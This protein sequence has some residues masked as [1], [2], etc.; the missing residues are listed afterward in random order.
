MHLVEAA[1]NPKSEILGFAQSAFFSVPKLPQE[2][3]WLHTSMLT[4]LT[5]YLSLSPCTLL[6]PSSSHCST[7]P[8]S[9][10]GCTPAC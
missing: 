1:R 9:S 7:P 5:P 8:K 2:Q 4:I 3:R 10:A 6:F